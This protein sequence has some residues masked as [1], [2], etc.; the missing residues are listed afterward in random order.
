MK[1]IILSL[2]A[3]VAAGVATAQEEDYSRWSVTPKAGLTVA[4]V[5]GDDATDNSSLAAAHDASCLF[6]Q[7]SENFIV[8][9]QHHY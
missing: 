2:F 9:R 5:V 4:T 6:Q 1:R 7:R 3:L 8:K